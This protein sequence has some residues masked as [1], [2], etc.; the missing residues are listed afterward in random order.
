MHD[1]PVIDALH[2]DCDAAAPVG[3]AN[4]VLQEIAE[5]LCESRRIGKYDALLQLQLDSQI[6]LFE[7]APV[8]IHHVIDHFGDVHRFDVVGK[9][10]EIR[11]GKQMQVF[12]QPAEPSDLVR[13]R[14]H[15]VRSEGAYAVLQ[16]L[17]FPAQDR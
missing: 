3:V 12:H 16:C 4:R 14:G 1:D 17:D 9:R 2:P 8:R 5:Y 15:T 6:T 11:H 13:E 10:A 7:C